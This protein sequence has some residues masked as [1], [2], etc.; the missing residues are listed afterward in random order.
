MVNDFFGEQELLDSRDRSIHLYEAG[1]GWGELSE[2]RLQNIKD[3]DG[4]ESD[5]WVNVVPK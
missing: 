1:E 5:G 3:H 2:G 4:R